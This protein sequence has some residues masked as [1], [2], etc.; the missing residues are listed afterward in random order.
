MKN[1]TLIAI[2]TVV[3]IAAIIGTLA[4]F[5]SGFT[6]WD[7]TT[8]FGGESSQAVI[9][10]TGIVTDKETNNL[11]SAMYFRALPYDAVTQSY[12]E[13]SV[14]VKVTVKPLDV[15]NKA[16]QWSMSWANPSASWAKGKNV[17]EYVNIDNV[18][19]LTNTVTFKKP[20]D[21]Q[22]ILTVRPMTDIVD[23]NPVR[24]IKVTCTID[25]VS[26]MMFFVKGENNDIDIKL[27]NNGDNIT[28]PFSDSKTYAIPCLPVNGTIPL[29]ILTRFECSLITSSVNAEY[30]RYIA[31]MREVNGSSFIPSFAQSDAH[32][33]GIVFGKNFYNE[34]FGKFALTE[35]FSNF[36]S[37]CYN[38][39]IPCLNVEIQTEN[40]TYIDGEFVELEEN[41]YINFNIIVDVVNSDVLVDS[42]EIDKS[43]VIF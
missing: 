17:T 8:W 15:P 38:N 9:K 25:C 40:D 30:D 35:D 36:L 6:N 19:S 37:Y 39:S 14:T 32:N 34:I 3:I 10:D 7:V 22:I 41:P 13:K 23:G 42:V 20:F 27:Q 4:I 28:L 26:E 5:S 33:G 43:G 24:D 31:K 21:E 11:T 12:R 2:I 16:V 18:S 29:D 1:N